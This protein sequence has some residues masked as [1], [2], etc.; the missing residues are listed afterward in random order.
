MQ[1]KY[2]IGIDARIFKTG[3]GRVVE[4]LLLSLEGVIPQDINLVVF[5]RKD[6][7][8]SYHP[9]SPNITK[10]LADFAPYSFAEQFA[11][12]FLIRK[13]HV[14]LM[15]FTNFN[16]PILYFGPFVVTIYDLIHLS[17]ST[18]GNTTKNYPYYLFKKLMYRLVVW[19]LAQR[20]QY[21]TTI[22]D[23]SKQEIIDRLH[24]SGDKV[25][26]TSVGFDHVTKDEYVNIEESQKILAK[27]GIKKP[28]L[29]Y[30]ATMYPHKNHQN[31]LSALQEILSHGLDVSL[32]LV[33]KVDNLSKQVKDKV[34]RMGLK[35][36]VVFPNYLVENGYV[37]DDDL[38]VMYLQTEMVVFPS[39]MEGFG[40][41]ILEA[42]WY[43]KPVVASDLPIFHEVGC[44][45][46][47]YVDPYDPSDIA[48]KITS[49]LR[50][51]IDTKNLIENGKEN[52]KRFLWKDVATK[53]IDVY[54]SVLGNA[55]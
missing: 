16:A 33:G 38:S 29:L 23:V 6:G 5:L 36:H 47:L 52:I 51:D 13:Y 10:V 24:V 12:P 41:P 25:I 37:L 30:V 22:S 42:Q 11:L 49:V 19:V 14:D 46:V 15:H 35:D 2:T 8:V 55:S 3:I 44:D 53:T 40:I 31:L 48:K 1:K 32:V 17:F 9:H 28:Y 39:L 43:E 26:V 21:I 4:N 34:T 50:K 27:Y 18:F 45:G 20:A 7:F 54:R